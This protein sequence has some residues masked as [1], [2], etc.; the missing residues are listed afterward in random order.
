ML[1]S[2]TR[3]VG[4]GSDRYCRSPAKF[5]QNRIGFLLDGIRNN[6]AEHRRKLESMSAITGGDHQ[7]FTFRIG[8]DPKIS[9]VGIAVHAHAGINNWSLREFGQGPRQKLAQI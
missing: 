7:S 8:R 3:N 2:E 5:F 4:S 1:A 6:F 9:I